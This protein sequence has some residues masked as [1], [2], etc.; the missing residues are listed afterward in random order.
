M[1]AVPIAPVAAVAAVSPQDAA[2]TSTPVRVRGAHS[3]YDMVSKGIDHLNQKLI[4]AD[5]KAQAFILDDSIPPHQVIFA[6]EEARGSF[7]MMMQIRSRLVEGYQDLMR[8]QL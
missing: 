5:A 3:F 7:Q 1:S 6:M 2:P 8:M 4:D